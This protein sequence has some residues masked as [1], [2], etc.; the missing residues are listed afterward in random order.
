MVLVKANGAFG[1]CYD[2]VFRNFSGHDNLQAIKVDAFW[3]DGPAA[4]PPGDGVDIYT[5]TFSNFVGTCVDASKFPPI[6]MRC[7]AVYP[8]GEVLIE[9]FNVWTQTGDS[10]TYECQ[11]AFGIGACMNQY[12]GN[13]EY[14]STTT[15]QSMD[16]A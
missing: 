8:C 3:P 2:T 1:T 14:K 7:G 10:Q 4:A 5:M 15:V 6:S 13:G 16:P 12:G 9:N 11:N